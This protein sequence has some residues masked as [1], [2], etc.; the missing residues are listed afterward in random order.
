MKRTILIITLFFLIT[1]IAVAQNSSGKTI[2]TKTLPP[3]VSQAF[4]NQ[5]SN[6]QGVLWYKTGEGYMA[7]YIDNQKKEQHI[8]Y[9]LNGKVLSNEKEIKPSELPEAVNNVLNTQHKSELIGKAFEATSTITGKK[10]YHVMVNEKN[11]TFDESG[12]LV[13]EKD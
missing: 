1:E 5:Y 12:T 7:S 9:D 13:P 8:V 2:E 11:L 4:N 3:A 10:T 6:L